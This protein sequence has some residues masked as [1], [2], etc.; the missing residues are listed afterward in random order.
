[1]SGRALLTAFVAGAEVMI[2]I[3]RATKHSNETR[4]FH[5]P[6]TT[7]PFGAAVACGHLMGFDAER[8][9]NA[10][11]IAGSLSSGLAE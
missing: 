6:G 9:T 2:R 11:G 8:M 10:L 7:G 5:A 3:G 4:G 1:M